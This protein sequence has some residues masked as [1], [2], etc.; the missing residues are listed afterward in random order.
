MKRKDF[1]YGTA[2]VATG[3]ALLPNLWG[4]KK[5]EDVS[6]DQIQHFKT[7]EVSG[8]NYEVGKQIGLHFNKEIASA[9]FGLKNLLGAVKGIVQSAPDVFYDPFVEAS[10]NIF[11]DYMDELHGMADGAGITFKDLMLPSLF[12]EIFY[13]Y[14]ELTG[15]KVFDLNSNLGCSTV[16]YSK[17]G[18]LYLAHNEDLFTSFINSMYVIKMSVPGKPQIHSLCYPGML[19]GMAPSMNEAGIVQTGNDICGLHIEQS[20]PMVF[21]FRSV[22]DAVSI[23]DAVGRASIPQRARTMTHNIGSFEE[24]KIVSI[25]ASPLKN[26]KYDVSDFYVHTN[27]FI[28]PEMLDVE[29]DE[30]SLPSSTSRFDIL[31]SESAPYSN[32]PEAIES[33]LFTRFLSSHVG[34]FSPCVHDNGGASTLAHTVFDFEE[35]TWKLLYSNPCLGNSI[36]YKS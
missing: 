5:E 18:S 6:S 34:E 16:A 36:T 29:I 8:T 2:A 26:E 10:Q 32:K 11:P 12:M 13:L 23:D 15:K 3:T 17:N 22:L 4:C 14:N 9:H 31:T 21:H 25:E 7:L 30:D 20:V 28:L 27:H 35:R 24:K 33:D 1:L 19:V